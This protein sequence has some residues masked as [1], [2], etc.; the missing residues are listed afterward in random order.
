MRTRIN[1]RW[2]I[3]LFVLLALL[4]ALPAAA[5]QGDSFEEARIGNIAVKWQLQGED[6]RVELSANTTGWVSVGFD[7]DHQMAGANIIIAYV[8]D[9]TVH[10]SDDY[11][12]ASFAHDRDENLGGTNDVTEIDG[13]E[14]DGRTTVRFT[15][16]LDSGDEKD[17]PLSRGNSYT[18][19]VAHGRNGADDFS[20]YHAA[21]GSFEMEL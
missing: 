4:I 1:G 21:R 12:T 9:G 5:Q 20:S 2:K 14:Q 10:L 13:E 17:K 7:P 18:V 16:P 3:A 15:I 11:G 19:L 6:L 8:Q